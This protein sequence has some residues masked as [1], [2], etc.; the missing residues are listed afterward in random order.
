MQVVW[1]QLIMVLLVWIELLQY[2]CSRWNYPCT[3]CLDIFIPDTSCL[4][5]V[6]PCTNGMDAFSL[7][8][9]GLDTINPDSSSLD[10]ILD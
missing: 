3:S 8:T 7:D 6:N 2:Q 5:S 10:K 4:D 1:M 9:I